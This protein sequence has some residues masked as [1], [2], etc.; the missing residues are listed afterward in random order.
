MW[1]FNILVQWKKGLQLGKEDGMVGNNVGRTACWQRDAAS[2]GA[3]Y[4]FG[5]TYELRKGTC[6]TD[7]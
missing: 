1:H 2:A 5:F 7:N 4:Y 3:N 6:S